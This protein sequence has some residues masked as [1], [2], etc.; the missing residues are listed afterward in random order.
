MIWAFSHLTYT[1]VF[2]CAAHHLWVILRMAQWH[3]PPLFFSLLSIWLF[4]TREKREKKLSTSILLAQKLYR[5]VNQK[6]RERRSSAKKT[7]L[8]REEKVSKKRSK[9][10][11]KV[12][13][14]SLSRSATITNFFISSFPSNRREGEERNYLWI[15]HSFTL[16]HY[17]TFFLVPNDRI[18][19]IPSYSSL[20]PPFLSEK[21]LCSHLYYDY[22][23]N[24]LEKWISFW[25]NQ[26]T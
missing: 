26:K 12:S 9:K 18:P 13:E 6:E 19:S 3:T 10:R 20:L 7:F 25:S 15:N 1:L 21:N 4:P 14:K 24:R 17:F 5:N 16:P 22:L 8:K 2:V 23:T 11:G